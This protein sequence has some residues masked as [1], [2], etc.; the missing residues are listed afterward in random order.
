MAPPP[1]VSVDAAEHGR[2]GPKRSTWNRCRSHI[3]PILAVLVLGYLVLVPLVQL[4]VRAAS[5]GFAGYEVGF[6]GRGIGQTIVNTLFLG[7]GSLVI[8][9]TLGTALAWWSTRL[10][11]R[12]AWTATLPVLPIVIPPVAGIIGWAMMLSPTSGMINKL[13]RALPFYPESTGLPSGPINIFSTT[14]IVILTGLSLTSFVFVFF[15]AGM[16]RVN[17]ELLEA[18]RSAGASQTRT[19]IGIVLPLIRPSMIYGTAVAL[20]L[21]LGQFTAPLLLGTQEN[22]RVLTT[23]VYRFVSL[24]P[25]DYAAAAAVA[26]PLMFLGLAVVVIQKYLLT[27][28]GRFVSDVGKGSRRVG[29]TSRVAPLAMLL[30]ALVALVLPLF[31]LI[32]VS[33]SPFWSGSIDVATFTTANFQRI[34][35][36]PQ[37]VNAIITSLT[38]SVSAVAVSIPVGYLLA[39]ILYRRRGSAAARA[40]LDVLITLPLGVPAVVF[41]AGFLFTYTQRPL[42]LYGTNAVIVIVYVALMLPFTVRMQLAARISMGT[43]YEA[44]A[45]VSGAGLIR[46]HIGIVIP[47]MRTAIGGAAALMFVMLSHEFAASLLVRSTQTQVMGTA[48]YDIWVNSSYPLVAA[49]GLLMCAVTAFGVLLAARLGGGSKALESL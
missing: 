29:R 43:S 2:N 16:S 9:L 19:F 23:E 5:D 47:M 32:V 41:G 42:V 27:N 14:W 31:A 46:A 6:S 8:A 22:I 11:S 48:F 1:A 40:I 39:D 24:P 37:T 12:F 49:M 7:L 15:R 35:E 18:A 4:Q 10:S 13:I 34:F 26:S 20:L 3:L 44:A 30:Y 17:H 36:M 45:R 33:L 25:V 21:G 28:E 38:V